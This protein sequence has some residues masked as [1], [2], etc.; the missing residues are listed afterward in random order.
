MFLASWPSFCSAVPVAGELRFLE[1]RHGPY[2]TTISG[3]QLLPQSPKVRE[4]DRNWGNSFSGW[5]HAL[6]VSLFCR[7]LGAYLHRREVGIVIVIVI[8]VPV[9]CAGNTL[10][11]AQLNTCGPRGCY[12]NPGEFHASARWRQKSI[13]CH[14]SR[15]AKVSLAQTT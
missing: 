3:G 2:I 9:Y 12:G 11:P 5:P 1:G 10:T 4:Q 13:P 15:R 8:V 14:V 6:C 7:R